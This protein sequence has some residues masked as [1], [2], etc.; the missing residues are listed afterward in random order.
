MYDLGAH[1]NNTHYTWSNNTSQSRIDYIWTD[2]FNIQFLLSYNLDNSQTS[3]SSDHSI[4]LSSWTFTNAYSKPPRYH[5]GISRRIFNFKNMSSEEWTEFSDL[6]A[7]NLNLHRTPLNIETNESID[8][9]WHKI[10]HAI[11]NAA[12]HAI[13]NKTT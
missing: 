2:T 3:T 9:T 7:H 8:T 12:I 1:T 4:L 10:E 13:P 6:L 11:I 5:T